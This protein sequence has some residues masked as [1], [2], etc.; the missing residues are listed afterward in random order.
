[1]FYRMKAVLLIL[2]LFAVAVDARKLFP[3]NM[4]FYEKGI[5]FNLIRKETLFLI[6]VSRM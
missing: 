2:I 3:N 1:M 5:V 6:F 4:T